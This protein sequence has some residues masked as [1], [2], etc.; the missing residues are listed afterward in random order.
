MKLLSTYF[1]EDQM[2]TAWVF[3]KGAEYIVEVL[4]NATH[5]EYKFHFDNESSAEDFAEDWVQ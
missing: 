2:R 1:S 4:D 5:R 3:D